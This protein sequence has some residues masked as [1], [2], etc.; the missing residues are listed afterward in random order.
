MVVMEDS[1]VE[2]AEVVEEELQEELVVKV[3]M[4]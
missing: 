1:Q 3:V 2:V 4:E